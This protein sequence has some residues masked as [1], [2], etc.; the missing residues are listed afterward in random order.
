[1][2]IASTITLNQLLNLTNFCNKFD[3]LF[4]L[5]QCETENYRR[6]GELKIHFNSKYP[7]VPIFYIVLEIKNV[8]EMKKI[9]PKLYKIIGLF[10]GR[11]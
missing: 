2:R 3:H 1:M 7:D 5:K 9:L 10:E 6:D 8:P 4:E 11:K